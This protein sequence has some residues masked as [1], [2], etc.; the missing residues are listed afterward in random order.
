MLKKV[1]ATLL[2]MAI[3]I[4]ATSVFAALPSAGTFTT[5]TTGTIDLGTSGRAVDDFNRH[6]TTATRFSDYVS[7][8]TDVFYQHNT[9]YSTTGKVYTI[10]NLSDGNNAIGM[11]S[12]S[13]WTSTSRLYMCLDTLAMKPADNYKA[14]FK[15]DLRFT[16]LSAMQNFQSE[17]RIAAVVPLS[18]PLA[19]ANKSYSP[20][21]ALSRNSDNDGFM[22]QCPEI[23]H[24]GKIDVVQ[25]KWYTVY[26]IVDNTGENSTINCNTLV[27]DRDTGEVLINT[28]FNRDNIATGDFFFRAVRMAKVTSTETDSIK[29]QV[30]N[31]E[32]AYYNQ[33]LN[34][35][36]VVGANIKNGDSGVAR[37]AEFILDFD[38]KIAD[39]SVVTI[40]KA[41]DNTAPIGGVRTELILYSRIKVKLP[42]GT[43]LERGETYVLDLSAVT[44]GTLAVQENISFTADD[45][46][47]WDDV[48][49]SSAEQNETDNTLT[50][51]TF[52]IGDKYNYPV[53]SGSVIAAVYQDGKMIGVDIKPLSNVTTGELTVSFD[54][55]VLPTDV[56]IGI[57]LLDLEAGPIPLASGILE[58]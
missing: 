30:D 58:N 16:D 41:E 32:L 42:M 39:D 48:S 8:G 18:E 49:V 24:A 53:F 5:T 50:D 21:I 1:L 19:K 55:G 40:R 29:L 10:D 6:D 44:N 25:D 33:V 46:H 7:K 12:D 14:V 31:A 57:I 47:L 20:G 15:Y 56:K 43:M 37:N 36:S 34:P 28:E 35:P 11:T 27:A 26:T 17:F 52:T 22:L 2:S 23:T 54:V 45:L 9:N 3:L 38:Q 51:I 4:S 13:S